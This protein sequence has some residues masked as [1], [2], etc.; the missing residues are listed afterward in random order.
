MR[1]PVK[2]TTCKENKP[3]KFSVKYRG[4]EYPFCSAQCL[5]EWAIEKS[6]EKP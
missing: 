5:E 3:V 6:T 1:Y 4:K 2:C